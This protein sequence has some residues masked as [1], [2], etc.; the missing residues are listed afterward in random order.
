MQYSINDSLPLQV[1]SLMMDSQFS[2]FTPDITPIM[3]AAHTNNYEII[4]LL[5]QRKV[6]GVGVSVCQRSDKN[7]FFCFGLFFFLLLSFFQ[8][9]P[10]PLFVVHLLN[11][12]PCKHVIFDLVVNH[13]NKKFRLA[14][15]LFEKASTA[16]RSGSSWTPL[17]CSM[18]LV[19]WHQLSALELSSGD[20]LHLFCR[21]SPFPD[22]TKYDVTVWSVYPVRR[23][24]P[25]CPQN[26]Q[27]IRRT[28]HIY[29]MKH[30][31]KACF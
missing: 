13:C 23:S 3:L 25:C 29:F 28:V 1:P 5:V 30:L 11:C 15:S 26:A 6:G 31:L 20:H 21:R 27:E 4:K 7:I 8:D 14:W 24:V 9:P 18:Q 16:S 2:E 17:R 12:T 22:R 10:W 19:P